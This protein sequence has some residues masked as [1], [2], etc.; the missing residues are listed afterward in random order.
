[1]LYFMVDFEA[2][3][4][5]N[6]E[7]N[8]SKEGEI[9]EFGAVLAKA[10]GT[11]LEEFQTF[12]KPVKNPV[13][14]EFCTKLTSITQNDVENAPLFSEVA[15]MMNAFLEKFDGQIS[16]CS[17]G[18][19]DYLQLRKQLAELELSAPKLGFN[20]TGKYTEEALDAFC[21]KHKE[22]KLGK[23]AY[24]KTLFGGEKGHYLNLKTLWIDP[25][26]GKANKSRSM[27]SMLESRGQQFEGFQ[28]RG[29]DD[30]RNG[31]KLLPFCKKVK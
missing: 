4:C 7:F 3:C 31:A 6:D 13:L 29:I 28:H 19:Y 1:M 10:D 2:T 27:R 21:E 22:Q 15:E 24:L 20:N 23:G 8:Q 25:E 11:I 16:M 9:I 12:V 17:V 30:A 26:T 18:E 14:T 5:E